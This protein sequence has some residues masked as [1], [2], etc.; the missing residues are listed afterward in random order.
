[1]SFF[2]ITPERRRPRWGRSGRP[3]WS[4]P[5]GVIPGVTHL[6]LILIRTEGMAVAVSSLAAYPNGFEFSVHAVL[7]HEQFTWG[8]S[9]LDPSADPVTVQYPEQALRLGILYPD[10]RRARSRSHQPITVDDTEGQDLVMTETG[11]GGTGRQWNGEFWVHPLPPDGP[12]TFVAS[13]LLWRVTEVTAALDSSVIHDA[14][15]RAVILWPDE[16]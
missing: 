8:K 12:V 9:P 16:P 10:G 6:G 4:R 13:W 5:E 2:D 11:T 1:V 7:H 14:A 15:R 3:I